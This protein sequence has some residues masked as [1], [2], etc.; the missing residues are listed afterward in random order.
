MKKLAE[1]RS[2]ARAALA[3]YRQA[4]NRVRRDPAHATLLGDIL[5]DPAAALRRSTPRDTM[6]LDYILQ[7]MPLQQQVNQRALVTHLMWAKWA[8]FDCPAFVLSPGLAAGLLLTEA[9]VPPE[10]MQLPFGAIVLRLPTE[11]PIHGYLHGQ[12]RQI[13]TILWSTRRVAIGDGPMQFEAA[14]LPEALAHSAMDPTVPQ[15]YWWSEHDGAGH[16]WGVTLKD[17]DIGFTGW[18][19]SDKEGLEGDPEVQLQRLCV[20]FLF[21]LETQRDT[22][23][24]RTTLPGRVLRCRPKHAHDPTYEVGRDIKLPGPL[25]VLQSLGTAGWKVHSR[26]MVRGHPREQACGP[27][28]KEHRKIWI[29]PYW[30]G[31]KDAAASLE[32]T[33]VAAQRGEQNKKNAKVG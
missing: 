33:Y 28:Q 8:A 15:A 12:L 26:F 2:E 32:R 18:L 30:K 17:A 11:L 19:G 25:S 5:V 20:N 1:I 31:P 4:A 23:E 16:I 9:A 10:G 21:W 29:E 3:G 27:G 13:D 24:P 7:M 6:A 14:D 22:E